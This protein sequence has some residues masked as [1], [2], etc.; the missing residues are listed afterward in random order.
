MRILVLS[1]N[2]VPEQNAPALRTFEHC[3]RW[4]QQ[5]ASVTVITTVPNFPTGVI[6]APYRNR[7][8]QREVME[9]IEVIRV[10]SFL[11][12][13]K[14]VVL[15]G[16]DFLSFAVGAFFAGLFQKA[17]VILAT[18]P[19]LLTGLAGRFLARVK[20][21]PWIFEVRDLWPESIVAVGALKDGV[22]IRM[23]ERLEVGLYGSAARIVT[24]SEP[25]RERIAAKGVP[26]DKI[27]V[28]SNGA[29]PARMQGGEKREQL[30]AQWMPL[31]RFIVGYIGTHGMA[32]GLEVVVAAATILRD[33]NVHFLFVGEG[34]RRLE[35]EALAR[36]AGLAN[37]TFLGQVPAA[38]AIDYLA[39]SDAV[40]VP[41]KKTVT[42]ES[43]LPSK[44]FET[45]AVGRPMIVSAFGHVADIVQQYDAGVA[46][47][48]GDPEQL[49]AAI[50][51]LRDDPALIE[52]LR[53]GCRKLARDYGRERLADLM[54]GEIRKVGEP[55]PEI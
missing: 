50:L 18:S 2:F 53:A 49:A 25:M 8:H 38:D 45:A 13:N 17:D 33:T 41:L 39:L 36:S 43:A 7:L 1:D 11:A 51:R 10:W 6:Q 24:V 37:T 27:A 4:V 12:P 20:V 31:G 54:L 52:R 26:A 5:G 40:V 19:Q 46:A 15:R 34:A 22:V 30:L 28:V 9:G 16:L 42:F 44:I 32:Q 48:P 3:R 21:T 23:L 35:L 47:E 55:D 14:D 29:D